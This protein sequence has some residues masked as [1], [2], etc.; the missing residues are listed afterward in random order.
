MLQTK[1]RTSS[2]GLQDVR[3]HLARCKIRIFRLQA[4]TTTLTKLQSE[5]RMACPV[6]NS[7]GAVLSPS[8]LEVEELHSGMAPTERPI[9]FEQLL[10]H[11][12]KAGKTG[13]SLMLMSIQMAHQNNAKVVSILR[14]SKT[15]L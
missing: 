9:A 13:S 10:Y 7:N 15:H 8:S 6:S 1:R 12:V 14:V 5:I 3:F 11:R 4:K 2:G